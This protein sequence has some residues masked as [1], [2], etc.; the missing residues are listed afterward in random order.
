MNLTLASFVKN[1]N[2]RICLSSY[3]IY[4]VAAIGVARTVSETENHLDRVPEL[5][6]HTHSQSARREPRQNA[7]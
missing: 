3:G 7:R 5:H 4:G 2:I 1:L 6:A